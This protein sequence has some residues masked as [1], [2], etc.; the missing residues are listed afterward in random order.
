M[1]FPVLQKPDN[2]PLIWVEAQALFI[3]VLST[4][5]KPSCCG[6]RIP[7]WEAPPVTDEIPDWSRSLRAAE[8]RVDVTLGSH[9]INRRPSASDVCV[10]ETRNGRLTAK[11]PLTFSA[12]FPHGWM[13]SR[14][15]RAPKKRRRRRCLV[16]T[17][18]AILILV[19]VVA[20]TLG[21]TL[22]EDT[23]QFEHTFIARCEEFKK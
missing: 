5:A 16:L 6:P 23:D 22:R 11:L 1:F 19:V 13:E 18:V 2:D 9:L 15:Y 20:V 10:C 3:T 8:E 4:T 17:L 14:E 21:L 12:I 7:V